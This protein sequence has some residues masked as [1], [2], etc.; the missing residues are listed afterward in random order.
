MWFNIL[1]CALQL[2]ELVNKNEKSQYMYLYSKIEYYLGIYTK[3]ISKII[4]IYNSDNKKVKDNYS[5]F[6]NTLLIAK[7]KD[8]LNR[9]SNELCNLFYDTKFAIG[10]W[11]PMNASQNMVDKIINIA[12]ES[13]YL[14]KLANATGKFLKIETELT[15]IYINIYFL[16]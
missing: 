1:R 3:E 12:K 9:I 14:T 10:C 15:V 11:P 6:N 13:F 2:I 16:F 7:I 8:M 4:V 5:L